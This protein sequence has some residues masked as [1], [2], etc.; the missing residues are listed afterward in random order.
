MD[1]IRI[2]NVSSVDPDTGMVSVVYHDRDEET[3]GYMP[4]FSPA[5]EFIPPNVDDMVLVAHLSNGTTRG[6]VIGKFWNK[7]NVPPNPEVTWSKQI[8]DDAFMKY[9]GHTMVINAPRILLQCDGAIIDVK[10]LVGD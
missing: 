6:V 8:A 3:T 10:D 7:A 4:Y 1:I 9:D 5:E 2:G